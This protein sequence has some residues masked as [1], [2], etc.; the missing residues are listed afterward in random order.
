MMAG[1]LAAGWMERG[2][3]GMIELNDGPPR[4]LS[5]WPDCF[6]L[7]LQAAQRLA[8]DAKAKVERASSF[9]PFQSYRSPGHTCQLLEVEGNINP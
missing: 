7:D 6:E 2:S 9:S 4:S 8:N 3:L 5:E 1:V